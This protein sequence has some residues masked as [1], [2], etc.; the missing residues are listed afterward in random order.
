MIKNFWNPK[1]FIVRKNKIKPL[2]VLANARPAAPNGC[3]NSSEKTIFHPK[4]YTD[5]FA[6]K[7]C[8]SFAYNHKENIFPIPKGIKPIKYMKW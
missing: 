4:L 1:A 5:I 7:N 3:I 6:A 2:R 8:C